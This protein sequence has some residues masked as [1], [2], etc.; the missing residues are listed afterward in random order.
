MAFAN[1]LVLDLPLDYIADNS[2]QIDVVSGDPAG[3]W[4]NIS[5]MSL[6]TAAINISAVDPVDDGTG[7]KLVVP[8]QAMGN[9][10]VAG[11]AANVVLHNG[12]N[13]IYYMTSTN[14]EAITLGAAVTVATFDI[15]MPQPA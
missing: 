4:A 10:G 15:S 2:T 12:T 9:V 6:G 5:G 8:E 1:D 11:T 13:T 14:A 7:R 3:V